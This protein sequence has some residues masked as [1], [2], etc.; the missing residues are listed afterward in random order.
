MIKTEKLIYG[1]LNS[2]QKFEGS[3]SYDDSISNHRPGILVCHAYGGH[4]SFDIAKAEKLA[5]LGYFAF[6]IDLYGQGRRGSNPEESMALMNEFNSDRVLLQERMINAFE[7]LKNF[8]QVDKNK[9]GAIGFCFGGK[10]ALDLARSGEDIKGVV[11]IHGLY[12]APTASTGK[13]L[14]G[15]LKIDSSILIL[16]GY[17]DP[18]ATPKSMVELADELNSKKAKWQIHAYGNVGHAFTN[19]EANQKESGLFYDQYADEHS[20]NEMKNFFS[21]LYS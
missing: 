6:A 13:Q 15:T 3:I 16:H 12:D 10:C 17:D 20:W 18:M 4:S 14:K 7:T 8:D 2:D 5:E 9:T 11:S 21:K 19:P 1:A